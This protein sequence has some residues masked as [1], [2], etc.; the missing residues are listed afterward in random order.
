MGSSPLSSVV[1]VSGMIDVGVEAEGVEEGAGEEGAGS[2]G[3]WIVV[4]GGW[5]ILMAILNRVSTCIL[6]N[7]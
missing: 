4:S 1:V 7:K 6:C 2:E 5:V 3:V